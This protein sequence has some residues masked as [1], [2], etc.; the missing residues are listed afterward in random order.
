MKSDIKL[1][2]EVNIAPNKNPILYSH[3]MMSIGSCFSDNIGLYLY[4]IGYDISVNPFGTQYNPIS[5]AEIIRVILGEREFDTYDIVF[6]DDKYHSFMHSSK[7]SNKDYDVFIKGIKNSI[8]NARKV[9]SNLDTLLITWGTAF[10]YKS[11]ETDRVVSNCHKIPENK[12][13]RKLESVETLINIWTPILIEIV[14]K[15]PSINIVTTVSPIRHMRDKAHGNQLSKST[16]ILF[17]EILRSKFPS[18]MFYFDAYEI[19]MDELRDYRYYDKD[20]SHPSSLAIDIIRERFLNYALSKEESYI[21]ESIKKLIKQI[22]HKPI[23]ANENEYLLYKN[24]L[25]EQ[26]DKLKKKYPIVKYNN[27]YDLILK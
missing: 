10:V 27:I 6:N 4:D 12:F 24:F 7:F 19:I 11:K 16:L 26:V 13:E 17:D 1:I 3:K 20:L 14:K 2:T 15:R 9:F 22:H 5:I 18:N 8:N 25:I 21:R 23:Y